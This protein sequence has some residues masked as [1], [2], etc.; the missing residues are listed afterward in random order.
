MRWPSSPAARV[1]FSAGRLIFFFTTIYFTIL[2]DVFFFF[3]LFYESI[4]DANQVLYSILLKGNKIR[5]FGEL[6]YDKLFTYHDYRLSYNTLGTI[7]H[8]E[9]AKIG[10]YSYNCPE[11][12]LLIPNTVA[13]HSSC[14]ENLIN[15]IKT[16]NISS[17]LRRFSYFL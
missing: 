17:V 4:R 12:N 11:I 3:L 10:L 9:T 13:V 2:Y 5:Q 1:R 16:R 6:F 7:K 8:S 15:S 14:L